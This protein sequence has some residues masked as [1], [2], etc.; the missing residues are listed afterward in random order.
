MKKKLFILL[1]LLTLFVP[2]LTFAAGTYK[3]TCIC[4]SGS[5]NNPIRR[6]VDCGSEQ[7]SCSQLCNEVGGRVT[8][9]NCTFIEG[10][11]P[12]PLPS[13]EI[14]CGAFSDIASKARDIIMIAAPILL[15]VLGTVDFM[16]A[17]GAS[18]EKAMRKV[19]SDFVKRLIICV[20]IL[21]LPILVNLI[22]G[23]T[24]YNDL[25]ACW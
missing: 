16:K 1:L 12:E 11:N 18:D 13:G 2:S 22:M 21:I 20:I 10:S 3:G 25:T 4:E 6:Q 8:S 7:R 15:L 9:N 19:L 23:W 14:G 5:M 17:V 24:K